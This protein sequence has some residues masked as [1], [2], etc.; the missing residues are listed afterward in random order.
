MKKVD[1]VCEWKK[2]KYMSNLMTSLKILT[3]RSRN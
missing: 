3:N 1:R 2:I